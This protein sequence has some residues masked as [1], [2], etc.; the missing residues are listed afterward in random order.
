MGKLNATI[1]GDLTEPGR[2][3]DGDGLYLKVSPSGGKSWVLRIQ[4]NGTRR[5][6]GL[7]DARYVPVKTARLEAAAAKKLAASGI[8][9]LEERRKVQRV[10][11]TFEQAAKKAHAEMVKSWKNG[12]H[13]KQWIRTLE[14]YAYPKLGKLK[15]DKI[16]GPLIR[17]VLA[18]I[19]LEIPETAR[20]VRQRIG[21]VLDW[22][23]AN[24]LRDSEAPM[25]SIS[26]GLPR[27]PKKKGHFAALPHTQVVDFL[28]RLRG[29]PASASALALEG[30][31]LTAVRSGEIRGAAWSELND[32]LTLWTIPE[33]R[34]KMGV[35]HVV[36]LSRQAADLFQRAL[37][38]R[39]EGCDLVFPGAVEGAQLSDMALL[40][41][42]RGMAPGIT[43]HGFRSTFRD[44]VAEET[45]TAD[46][47]AEASLAHA[48]EGK[49]KAAYLRTDF[50]KKRRDL[51]QAW[52]NYCIPPV[53]SVSGRSATAAPKRSR[54]PRVLPAAPAVSIGRGAAAR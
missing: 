30:A 47:V 2:Y 1:I 12:K 32:D 42:V 52:A 18:E 23:Y 17:D 4:V 9:P 31:I 46:A 37:A 21:T 40:E 49:T 33:D 48:V 39:V 28:H 13:T 3:P 5:D 15:V 35:E 51:M 26:K 43:V 50:F 53:R 44:W 38:I 6:I 10:V 24:G 29:K 11:L 36:P 20:R 22:C 41:L 16:D 14:L 19:W 54:K 34:M 25:R 7:G 8:D 27:Q 45:D